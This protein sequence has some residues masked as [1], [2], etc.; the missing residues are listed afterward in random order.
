[1]NPNH[2]GQSLQPVAIP[3]HFA[4]VLRIDPFE[5][6]ETLREVFHPVVDLLFGED[7]D[8]VRSGLFVESLAVGVVV[9]IS[10]ERPIESEVVIGF[11]INVVLNDL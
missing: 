4:F 3:G 1:M 8:T 11:W 6:P 10:E 2:I 5:I 9:R 7:P